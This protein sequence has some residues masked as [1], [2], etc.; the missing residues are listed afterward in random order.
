MVTHREKI[1]NQ[2]TWVLTKGVTVLS[3]SGNLKSLI[4]S[5]AQ[6]GVFSYNTLS[7]LDKNKDF[8][9]TSGEYTIWRVKHIT[10]K[11]IRK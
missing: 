10:G 4:E 1:K 8:P 5:I 3:T 2:Q 6:K 11:Y 9:V 7:K